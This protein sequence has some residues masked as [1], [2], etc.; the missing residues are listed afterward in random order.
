MELATQHTRILSNANL[1][2]RTLN[3]GEPLMVCG[4]VVAETAG[5]AAEVTLTDA[6]GTAIMTLEVGANGTV[7]QEAPWL[8]ENGLIVPVGLVTTIV[9]VLWRPGC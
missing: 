6:D 9:T 8:A 3:G 4:I 7:T 1:A 2:T 5:A